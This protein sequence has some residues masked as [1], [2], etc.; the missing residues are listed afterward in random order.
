NSVDAEEEAL[1]QFIHLDA[2]RTVTE[3][4]ERENLN[5]NGNAN[6]YGAIGFRHVIEAQRNE[7]SAEVRYNSSGNDL[8][9][10]SLHFAQDVDGQRAD[11]PPG[12]TS[13]ANRNRDAVWSVQGDLSKPLG[14]QT[15]I[16]VGYRGNFRGNTSRQDGEIYRPET[17]EGL[18][19][20]DGFRYSEDSH[21]GYLNMQ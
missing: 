12:L 20:E 11:A 10:R 13:V 4:Y 8:E 14:P 6:G 3:R 15:Q 16:E 9:T 7:M 5:D 21:A 1:S 19:F 18:G 2:D 17:D